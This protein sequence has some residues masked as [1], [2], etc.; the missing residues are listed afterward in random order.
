[1]LWWIGLGIQPLWNHP[2]CPRENPFVER[3]NGLVDAWG[4]PE[5]CADL[6]T[7]QERLSWAARIQREVYPAIQGRS[8]LHTYPDLAVCARPYAPIEEAAHWQIERVETYLAQGR[9]VRLVSKQGQITLYNRAYRVGREQA[10]SPVFVRYDP[11]MHT[12]VV[13]QT[14]GQEVIR[15]PALEITSERI[16]ALEVSYVKPSRQRISDKTSWRIP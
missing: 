1:V 3:C 13:Q 7:W 9:Y 8:R 11:K 14:N 10:G 5:R 4:E 16:R 2:H 15:H 6:T 12:W